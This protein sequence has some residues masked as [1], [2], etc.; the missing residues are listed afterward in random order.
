M[1]PSRSEITD[2]SKPSADTSRKI[3]DESSTRNLAF[4][5]IKYILAAAAFC[6]GLM[7]THSTLSVVS[8]HPWNALAY[9]LFALAFLVPAIWFFIFEIVDRK[10]LMKSQ[11]RSKRY[12]WIPA[13]GSV[14]LALSSLG[15]PN[16]TSSN[17]NQ[18][19]ETRSSPTIEAA[20]TPPPEGG[21]AIAT[22]VQG[23]PG[24]ADYTSTLNSLGIDYRP[25]ESGTYA[26]DRGMCEKMTTGET[27]AWDLA[28]LEGLA[29]GAGDNARRVEAMVPILCP[30]NQHLVDS[31]KSGAAVQTKIHDGEYLVGDMREPRG[32]QVI[33][34]GTWRT[35]KSPVKN[36]YFERGDGAGGIIE[37][38]FV[39]FAEQ[40]TVTISPSDGTFISRSCGGWERV[41]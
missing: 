9:F 25:G 39:T 36:C 15:V 3:S 24:Y 26:T 5:I 10:R 17:S 20:V 38:N 21:Q 35:K 31:A 12:S 40:L 18:A 29:D 34:P 22:A 30:E 19:T 8:S 2:R 27:D 23:P 13:I 28:T 37:N 32:P 33:Q 4:T 7:G 6:F 1:S 11:P 14:V 41:Q 16:Y